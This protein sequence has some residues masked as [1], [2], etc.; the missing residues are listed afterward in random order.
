MFKV[1]I[2]TEQHQQCRYDVFIINFEQVNV[3]WVAS[4]SLENLLV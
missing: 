2:T 4:C 3:S 1:K